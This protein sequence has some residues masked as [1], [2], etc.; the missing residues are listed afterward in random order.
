MEST[1]ILQ[2][3]LNETSTD[4]YCIEYGGFLSNHI[5]HGLIALSR[6][7]ASEA[8]LDRFVQWYQSRLEKPTAREKEEI[9][10]PENIL[11]LRGK[12]TSFYAIL[13]LYKQLLDNKYFSLD[14]MINE[15]FPKLSTG[16]A[17]AAFH[18]AIQLGYGYAVKHERTVIEG[19]AYLHFSYRPIVPKRNISWYTEFGK[20][21]T[22]ILSVF[23]SI[24]N[25]KSLKSAMSEG[26][27]RPPRNS[28]TTSDFQ[29]RNDFLLSEKADV[30]IDYAKSVKLPDNVFEN[31]IIDPAK[32]ANQILEWA[33]TVFTLS[34][35][36]N[37]F[38]LLHGVTCS[39]SLY[40][41]LP[42]LNRDDAI[43]MLAE[44]FVGIETTYLSVNTPKL[45]IKPET[46]LKITPD[47][48]NAVIE[49]AIKIDRDEHVYKLVQVCYDMSKSC[50]HS[51]PIYL[52]AAL[53]SLNNGLSFS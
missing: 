14:K 20:G 11:S 50:N 4:I 34:E 6:L 21:D 39:W 2:K 17:G 45:S 49:K 36:Q 40:Q 44:L 22:E 33:V 32:L 23:E 12:E 25:D 28:K 27:R 43:R 7:G 10:T 51:K 31:G 37:E 19:L 53:S 15:E 5:A 24:R 41:L 29:L 52:Q 1:G 30:L 9:L 3:S 38:F 46:D 42:V 26:A 16:I 8:R 18:G 35:Y 47:A 13:H 48:W